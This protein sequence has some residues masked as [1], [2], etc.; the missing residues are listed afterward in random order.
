MELQWRRCTQCVAVLGQPSTRTD[1]RLASRRIRDTPCCYHSF[2]HPQHWMDTGKPFD[3]QDS[4]QDLQTLQTAKPSFHK[5]GYLEDVEIIG[6][7][8]FHHQYLRLLGVSKQTVF[9]GISRC[10]NKQVYPTLANWYHKYL[11][12]WQ[13]VTL[14]AWTF[15]PFLSEAWENFSPPPH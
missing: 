4:Q 11:P 8:S 1:G 6:L 12:W 10:S 13:R 9:H 2:S 5:L 7:Y 3:I 14:V 15:G